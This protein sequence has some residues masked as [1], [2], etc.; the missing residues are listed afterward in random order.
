MKKTSQPYDIKA[1]RQPN[2]IKVKVNHM[3]QSLNYSLNSNIR[4][5]L[6]M[7]AAITVLLK[8]FWVKLR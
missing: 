6:K 3:F 4:W 8:M 2:D 5:G 7:P 1:I